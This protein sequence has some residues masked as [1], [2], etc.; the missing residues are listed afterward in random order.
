ML[1]LE[2]EA[3]SSDKCFIT[4]GG[5]PAF[6]DPKQPPAKKSPFT[7]VFGNQFIHT[8]ELILPEEVYNV[9]WDSIQSN[10]GKLQYAK[11]IL[12]LSAL[13]ESEFFN[14]YI[15]IGN[16]LMLSEG[17]AGEDNK[18]SLKDGV[19]K[20]DLDKE[21]YER[22]GLVGTA[23]RNGGRKHVKTRYDFPLK[24]HHPQILTP[25]PQI[26][27]LP[28]IL[29]PPLHSLSLSTSTSTHREHQ[30][31]LT[32]LSEWL[33]LLSLSSPRTNANDDIDPYLS[34][35][36]VP[37]S[38]AAEE[39]EEEGKTSNLVRVAWRGLIPEKWVGELLVVLL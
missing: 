33:S 23:V 8:T 36:E 29:V 1:G 13:L 35:Y 3:P 28:N 25:T 11:V 21:S 26:T 38:G 4:T 24:K 37:G 2:K 15:K 16:I 31:N 12:P 34:R 9:T 7:T 17:I 18:F 14:T 32:S 22:A 20:L 19:L 6:I 27:T 39:E 10:L 5:Y 30:D